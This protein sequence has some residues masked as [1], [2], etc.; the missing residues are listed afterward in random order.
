MLVIVARGE[1][2]WRLSLGV[3]SALFF[4]CMGIAHV[5]VPDYFLKRSAI[6]KGGEL[7][8]DLN[9]IGIQFVGIVVALLAAVM[10]YRLTAVL[11]AS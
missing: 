10:L 1:S 4:L 9:R 8:T 5:A 11:F 6:R 7:L 3:A 2:V